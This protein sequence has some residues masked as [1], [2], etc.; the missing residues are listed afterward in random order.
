MSAPFHGSLGFQNLVLEGQDLGTVRTGNWDFV[1][2][3]T[4]NINS[5]EFHKN[6]I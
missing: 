5:F 4:M 3:L 2:G 1:L 6:K